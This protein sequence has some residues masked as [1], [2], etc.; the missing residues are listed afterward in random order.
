MGRFEETSRVREILKDVVNIGET[1]KN[2]HTIIE[3][4]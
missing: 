3:K 2:E 1:I 4:F